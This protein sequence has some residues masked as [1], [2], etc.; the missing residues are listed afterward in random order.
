M[1]IRLIGVALAAGLAIGSMAPAAEEKPCPFFPFCI[2]WHD[3]KHRSFGE[4]AV[5]LKELGYDGVGHI[6]LDG[7]AQRLKTLDAA[8][9]KLF[10][11]TMVVDIAPG[12]PA[13]DPRF[14]EVLALVKGRHVQ[15]AL[16]V[17]GAKPSDATA[18]ARG[19]EVLRG[20]SD[21][22]RD[23]GSQLLLYPHVG[24]WVERIE[25]CVRVAEKVDRP[26]VGVMFNL[27]HWLRVDSRRDYRPLLERALPRLWAVSING[28]DAR[29][30]KPGW[31]H[32][33]QPLDKGNFDVGGLLHTLKELG[34]QGPV[35]LQCYGIGGDARAH[36]ARSIAAWRKLSENLGPDAIDAEIAR[37]KQAGYTLVDFHIHL[38]GGLTAE[39]A[40]ASSRRTGIKYGI[41][42]NCGLKFPVT[43]DRGIERYVA[44]LQGQPV[45]IGMQAEGREWPRLFSKQAIA[46]FDYVFTDAMTIVDHRGRRARLWVKDEV[47][48]PD[49]QAFMELLVRTIVEILNNEPIDIYVNP[50]YLPDVLAK[51]YDALWTPERLQKVIDAAA[52]NGVAIEI[53]NRLQLPK[54]AF[55]KQAK[56]AGIK[57]TFGTNNGDRNLGRMEYGLKMIKEC[58]LTPQDLWM[59]KPDGQ[60][61]VQVRKAKRD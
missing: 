46:K 44:S 39:E 53:S 31:D 29:D 17:N 33:I 4:Q 40:V 1:K 30:D 11:I 49:K 61:P 41:A 38:K 14:K 6:F 18:D 16:L 2:D 23:S 21:L 34:Y 57:F 7:V 12:K 10:Q 13:Y 54:P 20:M 56:Q 42:A 51:E 5:M 59:P 35:G 15:F 43:D 45:F 25:D 32:Y 9:L 50:T 58:G 37:L 3:A 19:V 24:D 27:C 55:I 28:A 36:L 22:A 60:K 8:G 52:A 26:N 48:I 47:D